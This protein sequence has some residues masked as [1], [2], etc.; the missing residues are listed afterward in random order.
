[1]QVRSDLTGFSALLG[2]SF[3]SRIDLLEQVLKSA[4]YPSLGSYKE[5]LLVETIR[6][7]LPKSVEVGTGFVMFPLEENDPPG[8]PEYHDPLNKSSFTVSRQC[9]II[10]YDATH[11]PVVFRD[12]EFVIVRPEAVRAIIEVKGSLSN[13]SLISALESFYDFGL[14][15]K[16]SQ[17]FYKKHHQ[18]LS[19]YPYLGLM[20][21][22]LAKQKKSGRPS[23]NPTK[24]RELIAE[25]Y[26]SRINIPE[27]KAFPLLSNLY[28]YSEAEITECYN[29]TELGEFSYG[30]AGLSGKFVRFDR[31]KMPYEDRDR[32]IASLL[33]S[34]HGITEWENFNRFFSHTDITRQN[35][36][37]PYKHYGYT[38]AWDLSDINEP[39]HQRTL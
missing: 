8:G 10:I 15:W 5:R 6:T 39:I 29:S 4:H 35:D 28:I 37:I 25:F 16:A 26:S 33:A 34:L 12:G 38:L 24:L 31:D 22:S 27:L 20:A 1:M 23:T 11:Y 19:N 3:A 36:A 18:P 13:Q 2:E 9:D 14:K 17:L 21:W 30:W 32:T 7:Y